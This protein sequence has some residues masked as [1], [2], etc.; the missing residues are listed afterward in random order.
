MSAE[1]SEQQQ[2]DLPPPVVAYSQPPGRN[3]AAQGQQAAA[4]SAEKSEQQQQNLPPPVV[5]YSQTPGRNPAAQ[6]QQAAVSSTTSP[7]YSSTYGQYYAAG[8]DQAG[9]SCYSGQSMPMQGYPLQPTGTTDYYGHGGSNAGPSSGVGY[10]SGYQYDG[11]QFALPYR[12]QQDASAYYAGGSV[13]GVPG[14]PGQ[15]PAYQTETGTEFVT[16]EARKIHVSPFAQKDSRKDVERWIR[17]RIYEKQTIESIEVPMNGT[18]KYLR[19]HALVIFDSASSA[20]K[21]MEQLNKTSYQG[22][23]IKARIAAEGVAMGEGSTPKGPRSDRNKGDKPQKPRHRE[24]DRKWSSSDKKSSSSAKKSSKTSS[25]P[26]KDKKGSSSTKGL[27]PPLVVDGSNRR[28]DKPPLVVDGSSR[29]HDK[30]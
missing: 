26:D 7:Q 20:T 29:R 27:Q 19:G 22:R 8:Y 9:G 13:P 12:D 10:S 14:V 18:K 16:T 3:P 2:Q 28:H 4:S 17:Q 6:G 5:A 11:N 25:L 23:K 1:K 30:R 15:E 21:A 24:P